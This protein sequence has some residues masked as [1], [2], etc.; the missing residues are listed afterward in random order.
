MVAPLALAHNRARLINNLSEVSRVPQCC[1]EERV[2][3][4]G[5]FYLVQ[6]PNDSMFGMG[7]GYH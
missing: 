5:P 1:I 6:Q 7:C 2:T 3:E 4:I